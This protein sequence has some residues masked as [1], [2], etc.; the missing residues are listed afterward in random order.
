MALFIIAFLSMSV[1]KKKKNIDSN[2]EFLITVSWD[3]N[4]NDDV[5]TWIEDPEGHFVWFQRRED[6]LMFL[7]RDDTGHANDTIDTKFG[8]V[9]IKDNREIVTL[10]GTVP[11]E[12]VLNLHMYRKDS[13]GPV[14][15]NVQIDKI[16]PFEIILVKISH[17][18][19]QEKKKQSSDS[20][21][22]KK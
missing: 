14:D 8:P 5:D 15:V 7:D 16:N 22:T 2:A 17:S 9:T 4:S 10:R 12:Y 6:G 3:K 1:E 18:I 19:K 11:G 20:P 13:L 21:S